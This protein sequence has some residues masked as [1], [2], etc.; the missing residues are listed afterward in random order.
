MHTLHALTKLSLLSSVGV[1]SNSFANDGR[2]V[3]EEGVVNDIL[4]GQASHT[5]RRL[6]RENC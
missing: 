2:M 3:P 6:K 5:E 1:T 4:I